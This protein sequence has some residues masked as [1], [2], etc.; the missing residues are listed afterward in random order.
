MG[1]TCVELYGLPTDEQR[2]YVTYSLINYF[3][4]D[5]FSFLSQ[6]ARNEGFIFESLES[7]AALGCKGRTWPRTKSFERISM[8]RLNI[9][10][11][12]HY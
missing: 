11:T 2:L 6:C 10:F 5:C 7:S 9:P 8:S 3:L 1:W 4:L 12:F